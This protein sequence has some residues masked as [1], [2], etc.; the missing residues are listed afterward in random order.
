MTIDKI[1]IIL[2]SL[3]RTVETRH[4]TIKTACIIG[5][6]AW[7]TGTSAEEI[8]TSIIKVGELVPQLIP[9]FETTSLRYHIQKPG[10]NPKGILVDP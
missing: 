4:N 6:L 2:N 10:T 3:K 9:W 5:L 1:S 8:S 7:A